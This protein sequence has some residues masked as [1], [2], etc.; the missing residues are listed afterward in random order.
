[1]SAALQSVPYGEPGRPKLAVEYSASGSLPAALT[2]A[3]IQERPAAW[4][5]NKILTT[6]QGP[7]VLGD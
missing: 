3:W 1:M 5:N 2:I 7:L 6:R 4:A